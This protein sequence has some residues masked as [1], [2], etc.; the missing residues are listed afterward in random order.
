MTKRHFQSSPTILVNNPDDSPNLVVHVTT[1]PHAL[2]PSQ[3]MEDPS[4]NRGPPDGPPKSC[5]YAPFKDFDDDGPPLSDYTFTVI[6]RD[7][8]NRKYVAA[9]ILKC[10]GR[11]KT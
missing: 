10:R 11:G 9:G 7:K 3:V 1:I 4:H 5:D 8:R 6:L 2:P